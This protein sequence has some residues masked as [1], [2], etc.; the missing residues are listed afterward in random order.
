[1][2]KGVLCFGTAAVALLLA[3]RVLLG[4]APEGKP[5]QPQF[6]NSDRCFACHNGLTTPSGKQVSIGLDWRAS[7]MA[8]SARD[9]YWQSSVR[10]EI[11]DHPQARVAV[12]DEC[13]VCHMPM[14]HYQAKLRGEPGRILAHLPFTAAAEENPLAEDGVSCSLCH[15][16]SQDKLG[17]PASF[18]GGFVI[19]PPDAHGVSSEYGPF[20][21]APGQQRIMESSTGGFRPTPAPHIR[22]SEMCAT[23]H[24]LYTT[25]L[26]PSGG[27]ADRFPEQ[28]PYLEWLHSDYSRR[29]SC[30]SC[31]MPAINEP[32]PFSA[33]LGLARGG[34]RQHSF[35]GAN[36]FMLRMLNRYRQDLDVAALP[37]ELDSVATDTIALLQSKAARVSIRDV[38]VEGGSLRLDVLV[39]N[40]TGHKLPTAYPSRRAWLHVLVEDQN[41]REVFESGRLQPDGSIAGND[42]DSD[43]ARFEP[44]Y[45]EI[46]SPDQVQIYEPILR[47]QGGRVTT[48]LL[49]TVAY[50]KD[51][52]LLPRGFDKNNATKDI[53]VVGAA[54]EDPDFLGGSDRVAYQAPLGGASGPFHVVVELW[55][56]PI[57]F[58]W[59]HNLASYAE[60]EPQ[61]FV[62][63]YDSMASGNAVVLA[64]AQATR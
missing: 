64:R 54:A 43:P 13:S 15:Q 40:L 36:F 12:E 30:Q 25:P 46:N 32:A 49:S 18:N 60:P 29:S 59:A 52:R 8:N 61:R 38:R 41:G 1:M 5:A 19:A 48:G 22:E 39:E 62:R 45:R 50:I 7:I 3:T 31:H 42:N 47:D 10:R 55:Y 24:T 57:G 35:L 26:V 34:W 28:M 58:R 23:C 20:A 11:A 16:I 4:A 44:H 17:T 37:Q 56:Q 63:Y 27:K 2:T 6:Q 9:P 14:A 33:V 51:N 53:A 21:I